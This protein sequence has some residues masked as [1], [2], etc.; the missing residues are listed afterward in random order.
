MFA[1]G[2]PKV[3]ASGGGGEPVVALE[4]DERAMALAVVTASDVEIWSCGQVGLAA[5]R[6]TSAEPSTTPATVPF[7]FPPFFL[8]ATFNTVV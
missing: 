2:W 7:F 4:H 1:Y 8:F 3:L 5:C 6:R